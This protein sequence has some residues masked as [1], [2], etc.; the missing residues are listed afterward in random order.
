MKQG[1]FVV[2]DKVA[3][4]TIG[5]TMLFRHDAAAVRMF[6]DAINTKDSAVAAHP[7]DFE[8]RRVGYIDTETCEVTDV[9]LVLVVSGAQVLAM[10]EGGK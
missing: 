6:L 2:Y 8:L 7:A 4:T 9:A 1:I 5:G 3:E 10:Q